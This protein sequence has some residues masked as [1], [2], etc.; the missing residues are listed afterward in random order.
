MDIK[1]ND[2]SPDTSFGTDE[3]A[4]KTN[5]KKTK[6]LVSDGDIV[7]IGG[8]KKN[9]KSDTKT[10]TPG[11]ADQKNKAVGNLFKSR[12]NTDTLTELLIFIA[13]KVI[14]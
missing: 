5:D 6:L 1:V 11:L 3:P 7:V 10:K 2:D 12:N 14:D 4:I 8:I 9:T 13:P